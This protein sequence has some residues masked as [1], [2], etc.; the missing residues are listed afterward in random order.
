M[1]RRSLVK[2][3][4]MMCAMLMV[5]CFVSTR[6]CQTAAAAEPRPILYLFWGNGCPHCEDEKEFLKLMR[7]RYPQL[8]M[9]YF[10]V[11]D[12][13]EFA[14]LA[15][16]LRQA[17]KQQSASVPMTFIGEWSLIGFRSFETTGVQIEEQIK[18]CLEKG[19]VDPLDKLGPEK[20]IAQIREEVSQNKPQNWELF[21]AAK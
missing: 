19:C 21:P 18:A 15:D 14:K 8:E 20:I 1:P 11:W 13:P 3:V 10:E 2:I 6:I 12:H 16:T 4:V 17:Y 5:C 9:R 7:Q